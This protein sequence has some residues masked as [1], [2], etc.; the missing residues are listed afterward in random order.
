M[1]SWLGA[2]VENLWKVVKG[3]LCA[4][5]TFPPPS[6]HAFIFILLLLLIFFICY[7]YG[8]ISAD[9]QSFSNGFILTINIDVV[10]VMIVFQG[11]IVTVENLKLLL[12]LEKGKEE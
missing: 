2:N 7:F 11:L 8:S 3:Y 12:N 10:V 4:H 9:S 6:P 1:H 5:W